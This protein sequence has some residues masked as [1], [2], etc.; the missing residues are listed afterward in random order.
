MF[1]VRGSFLLLWRFHRFSC[2]TIPLGFFVAAH[3]MGWVIVRF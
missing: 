1:R 2:V 3:L